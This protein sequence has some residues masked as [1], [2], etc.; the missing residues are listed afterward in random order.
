MAKTVYFKKMPNEM[1]L[2][3]E[4]AGMT[5]EGRFRNR[6]TARNTE[7]SK[8]RK[9]VWD[10]AK[11]QGTEDE[12]GDTMSEIRYSGTKGGGIGLPRGYTGNQKPS[13]SNRHPSRVGKRNR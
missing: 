10:N 1:E 12:L 2:V 4:I 5:R 8:I 6:A 11:R 9:R 7:V 13:A 3:R